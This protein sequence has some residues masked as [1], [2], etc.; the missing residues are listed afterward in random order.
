MLDL[1]GSYRTKKLLKDF[2]KQLPT[3]FDMYRMFN[4]RVSGTYDREVGTA[5]SHVPYW[6]GQARHL[7]RTL[8]K[9][10]KQTRLMHVV[11]LNALKNNYFIEPKNPL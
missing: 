9:K 7:M 8:D 4:A 6:A 2:V 10:G 1:P 5:H 3:T 11:Y